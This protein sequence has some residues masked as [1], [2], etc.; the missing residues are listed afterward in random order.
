MGL[1]GTRSRLAMLAICMVGAAS[2]GRQDADAQRREQR[3]GDDFFHDGPLNP[4]R[5]KRRFSVPAEHLENFFL[6]FRDLL[7]T[8][9]LIAAQN[10]GHALRF[11]QPGDRGIDRFL[12]LVLE[13]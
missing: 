8:E 5:G 9:F 11:R 6:H 12:Q 2:G 4:G 10:H 7:V 1:S 13:Q 3:R